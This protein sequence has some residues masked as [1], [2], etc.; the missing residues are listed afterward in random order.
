MI[1]N[2]IISAN[3]LIYDHSASFKENGYI[4]WHQTAKFS[5]GDFVYI[6]CTKPLK[7]VKYKTVVVRTGMKFSEEKH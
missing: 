3:N 6:Y 4:D 5:V 1:T 2:W 7:R